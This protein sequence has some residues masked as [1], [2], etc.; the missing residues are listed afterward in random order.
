MVDNLIIAEVLT[1]PRVSSP[2]QQST[3]GAQMASP[4]I[5]LTPEAHTVLQ[6]WEHTR[7]HVFLTGRAG[8]GKSTLLQHFR[9]TTRKRLVVLAPTGVAAVNVHGQT[10]HAFF[11]FGPGITPEKAR[12][13]ATGKKQLY[14]NLQALIIDEI[15]MVRAD[16]LD[17]I[18]Q[19]L[20]VNGPRAGAP[21]GGVQL[22]FIGD[23]YQLPPVV[24]PEEATL[25]TTHYASPYFFDA[26]VLRTTPYT[27]IH[28]TKVYRQQD[29]TFVTLLDAIRT[30]SV[31][32]RQ[33]ATLNA[34]C[35]VDV[36]RHAQAQSV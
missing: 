13:R 21:F 10:I 19:F 1:M 33:L 16:L 32:Q 9:T 12:R 23:L 8:T 29:A 2:V 3:G 11:G 5:E 18:D 31:D 36:A 15:S 14:R 24:L 7:Q 25:F 4:A 34:R 6:L 28:L 22:L 17:C 27:V 20:R 35:R 30:G 26:H